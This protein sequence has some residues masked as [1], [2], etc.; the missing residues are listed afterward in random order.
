MDEAFTAGI[1]G[2]GFAALNGARRGYQNAQRQNL[3]QVAWGW[4]REAQAQEA[5]ADAAEA[6]LAAANR[7]IARLRSEVSAA[8]RQANEYL[9]LHH[10][11]TS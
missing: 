11:L 4:V 2:V 9:L 7:E 5:R 1:M 10:I 6:A 3:Q 8:R